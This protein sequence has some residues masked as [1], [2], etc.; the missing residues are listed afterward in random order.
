MS[1]LSRRTF[2]AAGAAAIVPARLSFAAMPGDKRFVLIILRGAMDGLTAVPPYADRAYKP[3]RGALAV[4]ETDMQQLDGF[5]GLHSE[6]K[7]IGALY[8]QKQ[9]L[10]LHAIATPYRDRSHF[11]AQNLLEGG[12]ATAHVEKDGW[13]NRAISL[14]GGRSAPLGLA[15]SVTTPLVLSGAAPVTTYAPTALPDVNPDFLVFTQ[16]L[17]AHDAALAGALQAGMS[18]SAMV[19]ATGSAGMAA[20][21]G[22]RQNSAALAAVAAKMLCA[23]KGP[24]LAVL[25]IGGWDTHAGQANRMTQ[26]MRQLD[27]VITT[28]RRDMAAQWSETMVVVVSEFGRT[29]AANGSGGTDHGTATA[30]FVLGGAVQGGRVLA[31]WPGLESSKLYQGRD[32]APTQD[33]RS[34]LKGALAAQYGLTATDIERFVF[35]GSAAAPLLRDMVSA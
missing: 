16:K 27:Q 31:N 24:R 15:V 6:L 4:S 25:D 28:L 33:L 1:M 18:A 32:L 30:A 3:A 22:P 17:L 20:G 5:F 26:A 34:V 12:G 13:L 21:M 23:E 14:L 35:P 9:A 29:V 11:D 2:L 7:S 19:D 8:Q 10:V